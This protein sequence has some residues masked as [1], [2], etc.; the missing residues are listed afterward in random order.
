MKDLYSSSSSSSS[1]AY[2]G[3]LDSAEGTRYGTF[4][5][6]GL[7]IFHWADGDRYII[8]VLSSPSPQISPQA[9]PP[10]SSPHTPTAEKMSRSRRETRKSQ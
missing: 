1:T 10:S 7:P 9:S 3:Q 5:Y 8:V 6:Q 4:T 2:Q